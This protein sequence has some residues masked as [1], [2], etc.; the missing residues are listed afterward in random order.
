MRNRLIAIVLVI[1]LILPI[2]G[3]GGANSSTSMKEELLIEG[4]VNE[5][6]LLLGT[7]G[8]ELRLD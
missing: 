3:C 6:N 8:V 5:N 2:T 7:D 1:S 4:V